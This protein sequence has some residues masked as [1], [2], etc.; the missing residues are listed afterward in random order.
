MALAAL[1]AQFGYNYEHLSEAI[2]QAANSGKI[3]AWVAGQLKGLNTAGN[4]AKHWN[5][6]VDASHERPDV[7]NGNGG[8]FVLTDAGWRAFVAPERME[9]APYHYNYG[10]SHYLVTTISPEIGSQVNLTT[11]IRRPL[12]RFP[13]SDRSAAPSCSPAAP[14]SSPAAI[15]ADVVPFM[16]GSHVR[17]VNM[18]VLYELNGQEGTS[19]EWVSGAGRWKV[20]MHDGPLHVRLLDASNFEHVAN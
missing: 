2:T 6:L 10:N 14:S 15:S 8:W 18:A 5:V 12:A 20:R 1:N 19:V 11:G 4:N 16:P 7:I 17:V 3:S 9:M 13:R